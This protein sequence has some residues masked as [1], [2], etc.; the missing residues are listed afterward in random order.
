MVDFIKTLAGGEFSQ[1]VNSL[2]HLPTA[3]ILQLSDFIALVKFISTSIPLKNNYLFRLTT[4]TLYV[5][6]N[7]AHLKLER[8]HADANKI[9]DGN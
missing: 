7:H 5:N 4:L 1:R 3:V 9:S 6:L 2:Y 8:S